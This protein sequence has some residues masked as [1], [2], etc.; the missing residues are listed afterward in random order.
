MK[1]FKVHWYIFGNLDSAILGLKSLSVPV[2]SPTKETNVLYNRHCFLFNIITGGERFTVLCA[3]PRCTSAYFLLYGPI[4][5][6]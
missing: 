2:R 1:P 4:Y 5:C 6:S 3:L